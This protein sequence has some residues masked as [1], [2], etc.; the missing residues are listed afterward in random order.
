MPVFKYG[1]H[2]KHRFSFKK[3]MILFFIF[4]IVIVSSIFYWYRASLRPVST[5]ED[6]VVVT[7]EQGMNEAQIAAVLKS[8]GLIRSAFAYEIHARLSG[9]IGKMQAGGYKLSKN[10][11]VGQILNKFTNG[12]VA[13][14]LLTFLPAQRLDQIKSALKEKGYSESAIE[15]A[16]DPKQYEGHPVLVDK[17]PLAS[18]EGYIYPESFQ[19][20]TSTPLETVIMAALDELDRAL[21]PDIRK[22]YADRGLNLHQAITL[23]SIVEREVGNSADREIVA[24]VF[25]TRYERGIAL[26]SDPTALYGALQYNLEP[27]VYADT[28]YNT[29]LYPGLP[30]GPINNTGVL[31][32]RAVAFPA[33][34]DYLFF[35]SGDDGKTYFSK[36]LQEH[37]A[38]TAKHCIKLCQ[39]Y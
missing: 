22:A 25:L 23:A 19:I 36:T 17:P 24:Q 27:S 39:S 32:L 38:L 5:S 9:Q 15:T 16:L 28:P 10:L 6:V 20:T 33:N 35:V 30:P 18:L 34:T 26:G 8:K 2:Y 31:A 7:V 14:D 29:R 4:G 37:E 21:T 3:L 12:E 1:K 11:T 13:V